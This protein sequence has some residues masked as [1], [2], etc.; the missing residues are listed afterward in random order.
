MLMRFRELMK[1]GSCNAIIEGDAILAIQ[2]GSSQAKCHWCIADWV[3]E[4][5]VALYFP[6]R[7]R[8]ANELVEELSRKGALS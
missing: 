3:E 5:A 2:W 1:L 6:P 4:V 8:E 7:V